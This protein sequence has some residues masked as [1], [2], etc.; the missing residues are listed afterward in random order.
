MPDLPNLAWALIL[1]LI[2]LAVVG[3]LWAASTRFFHEIGLHDFRV[4][5]AKMKHAYEDRVAR[6][7]RG[8]E[9]PVDF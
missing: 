4:H 6:L 3:S 9:G 5:S 7:R 2:A 8:E 1:G